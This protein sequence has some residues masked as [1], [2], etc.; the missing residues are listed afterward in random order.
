MCIRKTM[1]SA[2]EENGSPGRA[3]CAP[4]HAGGARE[5]K[6]MRP[7]LVPT[8]KPTLAASAPAGLI[9]VQLREGALG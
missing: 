9:A 8:R 1:V 3:W 6:A 7:T 5:R 4:V 2:R